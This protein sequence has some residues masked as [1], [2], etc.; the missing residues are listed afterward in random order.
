[1]S[2]RRWFAWEPALLLIG[3]LLLTACAGGTAAPPPPASV[4]I[5]ATAPVLPAPTEAP[6][7]E[8]SDPALVNPLP[9]VDPLEVTGPISIGGSSTLFP[10]TT[11]V[12]DDFRQAGSSAPIDV[13]ISGTVAGFRSFCDEG[14]T[15]IDIV[16]ASRAMLPVEQAGCNA[17]GRDAVG[18]EVAVDAIVVVVSDDNEFLTEL[19]FA[20]LAQI[21]SGVAQTWDQVDPSYPALPIARYAPGLDSGTF[22]F[23]VDQVL[24]GNPRPLINVPDV[25]LSEDDLL[26]VQGVANSA[27][28]IGFFGYSFYQSNRGVLRTLALSAGEGEAIAPTLDTISSGVYP[29]A[30]PLFIYSS[31]VIMREK[32]HVAEFINYYL[33]SVDNIVADVG[34]FPVSAE[35]LATSRQRFLNALR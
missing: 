2:V 32:P 26:L 25:V 11:A 1:M 30:R 7:G 27:N 22:D 16:N 14:G 24:N 35:T 33:Q 6:T 8:G 12:V 10:L 20:Q 3:V 4:E 23:F 31:P 19:N 17:A 28:A 21:F 5:E 13:N 34:Y 9:P 18:F 15:E 29:L